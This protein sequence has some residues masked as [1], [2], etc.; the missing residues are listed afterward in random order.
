MM[1]WQQPEEGQT[2]SHTSS[3]DKEKIT[4]KV[5]IKERRIISE[6]QKK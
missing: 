3:D 4:D 1:A 2:L 5:F 6:K